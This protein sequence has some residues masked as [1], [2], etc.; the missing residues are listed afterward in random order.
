MTSLNDLLP[1]FAYLIESGHRLRGGGG[2]LQN[3]RGGGGK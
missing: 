3:G 1:G 2:V